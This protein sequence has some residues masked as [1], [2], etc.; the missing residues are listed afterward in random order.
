VWVRDLADELESLGRDAF[1]SRYGKHFLVLTDPRL[2]DDAA[3]FVNTASRT[4]SEILAGRAREIDVHPIAKTRVTVGRDSKCDI[5][6]HHKR[7]SSLHAIFTR[8]GGLLFLADAK[9][10]NGTEV[11]GSRL[12]PDRPAPVD[13][14]D[15]LRFGP[16]RATIWSLDDVLAAAHGQSAA[17]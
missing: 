2:I 5:S 11:N 7:V 14:G 3:D 13:A 15:L 6:I 16:V 8:G 1:V 17:G 9:S 10:K 12:E 4:G